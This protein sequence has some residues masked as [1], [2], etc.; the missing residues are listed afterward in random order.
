MGDFAGEEL[1]PEVLA[2]RET[3]VEAVPDTGRGA[4]QERR[5]RRL[6]RRA[7]GLLRKPLF[8]APRDDYRVYPWPLV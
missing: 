4:A 2:G 6:R 7:A 3:V 1:P 8:P 5:M